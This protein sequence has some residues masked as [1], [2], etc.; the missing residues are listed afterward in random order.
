MIGPDKDGT[1]Q[2][3]KSLTEKLNLNNHVIFKGLQTLFEWTTIAADNDI[4]INTTNHDN[5][6]V[7]VVEALSLG[8]VTISTNVGGVPFLINNRNNGIL[9]N[10][11]DESAFADAI[12]EVLENSDL[13]SSLSH[14]AGITAAQFD[15]KVIKE[16]WFACLT[17]FQIIS[18]S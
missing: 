7:S 12:T 15:W 3:C 6:P 14:R 5:L 17:K 11:N 18:S 2:A 8:M 10:P 16:K 13:S 1:M 4:F 9:V